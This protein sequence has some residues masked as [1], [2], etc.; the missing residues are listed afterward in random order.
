MLEFAGFDWDD[1]NREKCA[2]H[3]VSITEIESVFGRPLLVIPDLA[4]SL[5]EERLRII[6]RAGSGRHIFVVFTLRTRTTGAYVRPISARYMHRKE[7]VTYEEAN[8]NAEKNTD[9]QDR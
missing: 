6:G 1:G 7:V 3:G 4:H 5:G 8:P 2:K 9:L